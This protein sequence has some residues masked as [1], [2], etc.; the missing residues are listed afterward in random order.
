MTRTLWQLVAM[1]LVL[2]F[3]STAWAS[4]SIYIDVRTSDEFEAGHVSVAKHIPY[5]VIA[6]RIGEVT[7]D[8]DAEIFLYCRSGNRAG[9]AQ[10]T[11]E[12]MGYTN[13]TNLGGLEEARIHASRNAESS[14]IFE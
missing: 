8:K 9:K 6:E 11:L 5:D 13:V 2:L 10:T 14:L 3:S 1:G 4:S 12:E 7:T